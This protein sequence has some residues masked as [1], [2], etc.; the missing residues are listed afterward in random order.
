M[1]RRGLVILSLVAMIV[2]SGCATAGRFAALDIDL[3]TPE[4]IEAFAPEAEI[5]YKVGE[6][7]APNGAQVSAPVDASWVQFLAPIIE[8]FK[9]RVRILSFEWKK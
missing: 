8:V 5:V 3:R 9:G 2:L 7:P 4:Q 6:A 1:R